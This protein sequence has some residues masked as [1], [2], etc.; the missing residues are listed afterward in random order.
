TSGMSGTSPT[1]GRAETNPLVLDLVEVDARVIFGDGEAQGP[2]RQAP[3]RREQVV[4]ID[5]LVVLRDDELDA[6]IQQGLLLIEDVEGRALPD[7]GFFADTGKRDLCGF[8][9]GLSGS[10]DA[11]RIL[12]RAPGG[13]HR[14]AYV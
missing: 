11:E 12:I 1:V 13:D 4:G 7:L 3:N 9:L 5:D 6:R 10:Q 14:G 2:D 8:H